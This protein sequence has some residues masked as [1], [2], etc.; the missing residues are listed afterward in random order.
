[1]LLRY[2]LLS[3]RLYLTCTVCY[4]G[5][6][7][8][9]S[10]DWSACAYP[11]WPPLVMPQQPLVLLSPLLQS[12]MRLFLFDDPPNEITENV[13][14]HS[15]RIF[16]IDQLSCFF[17]R[18]LVTSSSSSSSQSSA[19]RKVDFISGVGITNPS[20]TCKVSIRRSIQYTFDDIRKL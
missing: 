15:R 17:I 9:S 13:V 12:R 18:R 20:P 2:T 8:P 11:S 4:I 16:S 7:D 3:R 14:R 10:R 1:M 5:S 19:Y 6:G